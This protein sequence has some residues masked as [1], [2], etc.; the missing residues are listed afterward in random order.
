[1]TAAFLALGSNLGDRRANLDAAIAGLQSSEQLQVVR[2]SS[3]HE[4]EPVGGPVGQGKYLNAVAHIETSLT[5]R[6]LLERLHEIE[7]G[8]G[9]VRSAKD[10]PRTLDL[11]ILL[12]GDQILAERTQPR[13]LLIPHPRI[14]DRRFVLEPWAEIAPR[15]RHPIFSLTIAELLAELG[16]RESRQQQAS[17]GRELAG[18]RA[19]VTGS[20]SGI[21]HA[22]ALELAGAGADVLIHGRRSRERA[23]HVADQCRQLGVRA[24]ILLADVGDASACPTL[25]AEAW[26]NWQGLDIAVLNAGADTLTGEAT[27]WPFEKKLEALL[28]IDVRGAMLM[29]RAL[30]ERMKDRGQGVLLTLGWDQAETGMEG[31]S[32][33]LFGATKGAVMCF[34][35]SIA[36]ALAPEVRVHCIAPGWIRT[37]WGEKAADAWQQRVL[38]ETPL[39]RW[40]TPEDVARTARWLASPAAKYLTGQILRVNGG[41]IRG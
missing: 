8:A 11:D 4:T 21:G 41:A 18:M 31:D 16:Q 6:Q 12:F 35:K 30:G 15:T 17:A 3:F 14:Q 26:K 25:S 2:V 29:A 20:T 22:I 34:T 32:G 37:A 13:R 24:D 40:G 28:N 39:A 19:L 33:Q 27:R 10:A 36:L 38:R 7:D 5:P 23:E 1:M 9:R